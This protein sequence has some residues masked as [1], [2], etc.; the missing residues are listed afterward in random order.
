M[1]PAK[2]GIILASICFNFLLGRITDGRIETSR[3]QAAC[4]HIG[5]ASSQAPNWN[6]SLEIH[7][8][9]TEAIIQSS[10]SGVCNNM[11]A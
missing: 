1:N 7:L 5:G 6:S 2:M 10:T 4:R 11:G 3:D 9:T 8:T